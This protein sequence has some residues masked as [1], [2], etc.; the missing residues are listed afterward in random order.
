VGPETLPNTYSFVNNRWLNLANP[1]PAGSTPSLPVA[2]VGGVYGGDPM[3]PTDAAHAWDFG[4]GKWIVNAN[5]TQKSVDVSAFQSLRRAIPGSGAEFDPLAADP[6]VGTWTSQALGGNSLQLPAFS[7]VILIDPATC[8]H[9]LGVVGDY[10]G[11]GVVNTE[12]FEGWRTA[13]GS[14]VAMADGNGDGIVNAAD[15]VVWRKVVGAGSGGDA[16][17]ESNASFALW[18]AS[19]AGSYT[20][21]RGVKKKQT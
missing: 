20:I 1:T 4:W 9:C 21:V 5:A 3:A 10:D 18:L 14:N 19:A 11:N 12:D 8:S 6:L 15:Y 16:V 17:P 13:F 7:Q 2:E